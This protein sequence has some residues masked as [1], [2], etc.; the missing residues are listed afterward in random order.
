MTLLGENI[1]I[2]LM[3]VCL[4]LAGAVLVYYFLHIRRLMFFCQSRISKSLATMQAMQVPYEE[5]LVEEHYSAGARHNRHQLGQ[6]VEERVINRYG[7]LMMLLGGIFERM[8]SFDEESRQYLDDLVGEIDRG[9]KIS[10]I[11]KGCL[12]N[13]TLQTYGLFGALQVYCVSM[14][15]KDFDR[16]ELTSNDKDRRLP[17]A[18]EEELVVTYLLLFIYFTFDRVPSGVDMELHFGENQ[19]SFTISD[20]DPDGVN[21]LALNQIE[22]ATW[23]GALRHACHFAEVYH[24]YTEVDAA[25]ASGLRFAI[26]IPYQEARRI[27]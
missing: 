15:E 20:D 6:L 12:S 8:D 2:I 27:Y 26:H 17:Q 23:P 7:N 16:L 21:G 11:L 24:G 9:G 4:T 13:A 10:R 3:I 5:A 18:F 14:M 1:V 22:P 25:Y 19:V